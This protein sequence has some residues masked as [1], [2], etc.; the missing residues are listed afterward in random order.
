[1]SLSITKSSEQRPARQRGGAGFTLIEL[2]VVIAIIA[3]LAAMLLPALSSA[4]ERAYRANCTSNLRQ[5]GVGVFMY[6]SDHKDQ[7][8]AVKFRTANSWYPYEMARFNPAP[9]TIL[10]PPGWENLGYLWETKLITAPKVFYCPSNKRLGTDDHTYEYYTVNGSWPNGLPAGGNQYVR[11]GYSYFPQSKELDIVTVG[12]GVG[13]K[14]VPKLPVEAD[15]SNHILRSQ[16]QNEID[17]KRSMIVDVINTPSNPN[18]IDSLSHKNNAKAAG[19]EACFSDGHVV[20][21]GANRL[22]AAFDPKVWY[23]G[24]TDSGIGNDGNIYRYVMSLWQP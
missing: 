10:D 16:K 14:Q 7:L 21:Q 2:L 11:S 8:P 12:Y 22:P 19:L 4:K 20:W 6:A 15:T 1:M 17:P 24:G 5:L 3:I 23:G 13:V 9:P 18:V